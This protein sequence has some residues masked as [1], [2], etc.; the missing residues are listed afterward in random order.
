MLEATRID[1]PY[2]G[3]QFEISVDCSMGEE[4]Y[5]EDCPVCCQPVEIRT[6]VDLDGKLLGVSAHRN[7]D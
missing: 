3:E 7:D 4:Q 1:C 2:C 5:V 6:E